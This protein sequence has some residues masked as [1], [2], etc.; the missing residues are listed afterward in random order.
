[1]AS[2][3]ATMTPKTNDVRAARIENMMFVIA[4]ICKNRKIKRYGRYDFD[5]RDAKNNESHS[6]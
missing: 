6:G 5:R 3:H 2:V 1:M 4:I